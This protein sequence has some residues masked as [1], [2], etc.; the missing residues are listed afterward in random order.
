MIVDDDSPHITMIAKNYTHNAPPSPYLQI[1]M[2]FDAKVKQ[3]TPILID[4]RDD[5][6]GRWE[7][8]S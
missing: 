3:K 4:D 5:R 8:L 2:K 1:R 7:E 6:D